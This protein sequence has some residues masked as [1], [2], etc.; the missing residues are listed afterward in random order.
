MGRFGWRDNSITVK[1]I[2]LTGS[3]NTNTTAGNITKAGTAADPISC[4]ALADTNFIQ[5]YFTTSAATG[6]TR[7]I[8]VRT[9]LTGGAGGE[10]FRAFNTVSSAAP[11]DTVNGAHISLNF[12][13]AAGNITGLGTAVRATLHIPNRSLTGTTA[14]VQAELF[15][16]GTSSAIGGTTS[17]LRCVNDGSANGK[18]AVDTSGYF[19]TTSGL[20]AAS[21]K[22]LRVAAPTTLAASL[23][24]NIEGTA[25]YLPL[26]SAAG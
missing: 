17:F 25:Y 16:D 26:Y 1:R 2:D 18:A 7:G 22:L 10:A 19:F 14:A 12:G 24:V 20:T 5:Y 21:G 11:A 23:R 3:G 9:Y 4:G 6:T 8:Y 15:S 13:S